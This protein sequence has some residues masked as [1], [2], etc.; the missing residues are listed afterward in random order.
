M[1]KYVIST[2]DGYVKEA[3]IT[4]INEQFAV[5]N[6]VFTRDLQEAKMYSQKEY[7]HDLESWEKYLG[8][9]E[10][11]GFCFREAEKKIILK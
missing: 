11:Y 10:N 6:A 4:L 8:I 9:K 2:P 7:Q 1:K 3:D 5:A